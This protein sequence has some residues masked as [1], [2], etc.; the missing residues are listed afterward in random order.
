MVGEY[1][2]NERQLQICTVFKGVFERMGALEKISYNSIIGPAEELLEKVNGLEDDE[3]EELMER[4][5][6]LITFIKVAK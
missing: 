5:I 2:L 3:V 1:L 6:E 4:L